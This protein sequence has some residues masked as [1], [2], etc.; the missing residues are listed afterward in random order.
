MEDLSKIDFTKRK[1]RKIGGEEISDVISYIKNF[2][3]EGDDV[4]I[5]VGCDSKQ[6]R[7]ITLYSLVIV[8][9]DE[10]KHN[11]AHVIYMRMRTPKERVLFNR[12]MSEAIYSLNLALWLDDQIVDF[13][14]T[15]KFTP[16]EYD[17]S[18]PTRKIEIHVDVNPEEGKNKRNKSNVAYQSIMGMLCSSGFRVKSKPTAYVASCAA[19]YLVR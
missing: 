1:F 16:N 19:D 7:R 13:Y 5:M 6:K 9:Y 10:G 17:N 8:L 2:V 4:R 18:T 3:K 12:I 15:P 14:L 11:G